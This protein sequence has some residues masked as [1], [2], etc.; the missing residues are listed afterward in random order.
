MSPEQFCEFA[1][2][3]PEPSLL[4]AVSGEILAANQPAAILLGRSR[5]ALTEQTLIE[6]ISE[7]PEKVRS[8]LLSCAT[9]RQMV[10]ASLNFHLAD[11]ESLLCRTD[12]AVVEP[13]TEKASAKILLR[14]Q[15]QDDASSNFGLLTQKI[16]ELTQEVSQ[17]RQAQETL[18]RTHEELRQAQLQNE[19]MLALGSLVAGVAHEINNPIGF[20]K[21]SV[22]NT[23][24]YAENL[25]NHIAL[26]QQHYPQAVES[27]QE[28]EEDIDLDFIRE[29]FPNLLDSMTKAIERIQD[30][31]TSLRTF[32][33]A[34]IDQKVSADIHE[35]LDSTLLILKYRLKADE[36]RP[37]IE[38]IKN[39][40]ALPAL[41]C[42]PGQLNQVFM[43]ILANAI[44]AFDEDAQQS[45]FDEVKKKPY[46]ITVE[47]AVL[48]SKS[49]VEVRIR[50]N[51]KGMSEAV[52]NRVFDRL[53]TTKKAGKGTGLG[54][55]IVRQIIV[56][57]HHGKIEVQSELEQGT[58]FRIQL[59]L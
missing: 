56:E 29:D 34:D 55:A 5:K 6:R 45:S 17:R 4:V 32:S 26:Y 33:R 1:R 28:S 57:T 8:Y 50:D 19:K 43:N 40:G 48:S 42:F 38:V 14:L 58:E 44:D 35:G 59:P 41:C 46:V 37:A 16:E 39:Y 3:L 22:G 53:F 52:K 13:K 30:I 15:R 23:S 11:G 47:T 21:G 20:L 18:M 51:G 36:Y 2:V 49:H 25:L 31:S 12:G 9:S 54:L 7:S 24:E 10:P 27:I